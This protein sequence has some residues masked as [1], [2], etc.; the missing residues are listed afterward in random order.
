M[1]ILVLSD[2]HLEF[3]NLSPPNSKVDLVILAG[4][5]WKKDQ[6]IHWARATWP[7]IPIIYLAGNHEFYRTER[8]ACLGALR[9]SAQKANVHFL[10]ND[11]IEIGRAHV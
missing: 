9:S 1:K 6:G 5:I 2:L 11:E 8:N 4:D 10:E 7:T 3:A